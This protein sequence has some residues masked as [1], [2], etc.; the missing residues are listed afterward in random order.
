MPHDLGEGLARGA[1]RWPLLGLLLAACSA[2]RTPA[3]AAEA[4]SAPLDAAADRVASAA[5][6]LPPLLASHPAASAS[7]VPRSEWLRLAFAREIEI[8]RGRERR[9]RV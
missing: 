4:G 7:D 8:G 1:R 2:E 5:P 3:P 6:A 9:A